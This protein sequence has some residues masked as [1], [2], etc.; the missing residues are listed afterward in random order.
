MS[1]F[2]F[3][4]LYETLYATNPFERFRNERVD[5]DPE[6]SKQ[7]VASRDFLISQIQGQAAS[8]KNFPVITGGFLPFGSFSRKNKIRP[9]DDVDLLVALN[10]AGTM[11]QQSPNDA[12]TWWLRISNPSASLAVF[13]DGYGFVNS[14]K[15]LNAIRDGLMKVKSYRRADL[16]KDM[17]AVVLNLTSYPWNFDVVPAVPIGNTPGKVDYYLI[18]DGTGNWKRTDPRVDAQ[19]VNNAQQHNQLFQPLCRLLK[20]WNKRTHKPVLP[21]YYFEILVI[22]VF[23]NRTITSLKLGL[24]DFF[25]HAPSVLYQTCPDPKR[26]GSNLDADIDVQTKKKVA[27]AMDDARKAVTGAQGFGMFQGMG[28]QELEYWRRVFGQEYGV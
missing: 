8:N 26:L 9:L 28:T 23:Q 5:L 7:A 3:G 18:P 27:T 11:A 17:E 16:K 13:P 14:T 12:N 2:N 22:W 25:T 4:G 6:Q 15:V 1:T 19:L 24:L 20:Y 21:S 10:G